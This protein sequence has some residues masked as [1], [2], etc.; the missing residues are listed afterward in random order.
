V[1]VKSVGYISTSAIGLDHNDLRAIANTAADANLRSGITGLLL[2]NGFNF[3]QFIEG[4]AAAIDDCFARIAIDRRHHGVVRIRDSVIASREF[5]GWSMRGQMVPTRYPN[6]MSIL[7]DLPATVSAATRDILDNF[8]SI[9]V[10][11]V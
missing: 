1:P 6:M 4:D 7:P 3:L 8:S 9:G 5:A 2:F 11:L 10:E